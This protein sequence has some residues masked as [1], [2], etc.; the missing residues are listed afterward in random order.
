MSEDLLPDEEANHRL[1]A[2]A[3]KADVDPDAALERA[4]IMEFDG[5]LSRAESEDRAIADLIRA[6]Y[7]APVADERGEEM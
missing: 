3:I 4:G 5:G 1:R 6:L 2:R 7:K